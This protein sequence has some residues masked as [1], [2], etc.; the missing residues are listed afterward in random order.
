[1][2]E[3]H[4]VGYFTRVSSHDVIQHQ[5]E[6]VEDEAEAEEAQEEDVDEDV[7]ILELHE[8]CVGE[9]RRQVVLFEFAEVQGVVA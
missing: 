2:A 9:K 1:M 5:Y 6:A 8:L 7:D 3:Q 4:E